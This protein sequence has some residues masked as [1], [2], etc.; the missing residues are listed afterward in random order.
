M[1]LGAKQK[2]GGSVTGCHI[3]LGYFVMKSNLY[4]TILGSYD[5]VIGMEWSESHDVILNC[6]MKRFILIDDEGNKRVIV[7]RN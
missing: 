3:N 7:G 5:I 2:L 4:V 6:K 1:S